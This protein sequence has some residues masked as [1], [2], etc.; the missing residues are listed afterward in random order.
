MVHLVEAY[1]DTEP[2]AGARPPTQT[3]PGAGA[4]PFGFDMTGILM[5]FITAWIL[6]G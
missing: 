2:G 6:F 5:N 4:Q 1:P 3:S